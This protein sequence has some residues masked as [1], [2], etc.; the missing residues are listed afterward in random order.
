MKYL[1]VE[2]SERDAEGIKRVL[3]GRFGDGLDI[4]VC[5]LSGEVDED[6][7][8]VA[9]NFSPNLIQ[10][11]GLDRYDGGGPRCFSLYDALRR[12]LPEV[13]CI[14]HSSD[15]SVEGTAG[16]REITYM[17]KD[18]SGVAALCSYVQRVMDEESRE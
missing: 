3:E 13:E 6:P 12:E 16:E 10:L 7:V 18:S 8:A 17:A 14:I 9:K 4:R 11:D 2:D 15:Y 1:I 5:L